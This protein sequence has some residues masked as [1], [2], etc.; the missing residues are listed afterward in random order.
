MRVHVDTCPDNCRVVEKES[1]AV[2]PFVRWADTDTRQIGVVRVDGKG[3]IVDFPESADG[4][5][6]D[7]LADRDFRIVLW[8]NGPQTVMAETA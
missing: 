5:F 3:V 7:V 1:G 2:I 6:E 4:F 8:D